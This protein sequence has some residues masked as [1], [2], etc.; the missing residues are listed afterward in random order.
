M[1]EFDSTQNDTFESTDFVLSKMR[2]QDGDLYHSLC[3]DEDVMRYVTGK[4]L[5]RQESEAMF[6]SFMEENAM[7]PPFGRY[8]VMLKETGE[9]IGSAKLE[10][11]D[12]AT[13]IG[14]RLQQQF[15]GRGLATKLAHTLLEYARKKT[16]GRPVIAF[17]NS[18][19]LASIR[20]LQKV[21][22]QQIEAYEYPDELRLKYMY[23]PKSIWTMKTFLFIIFGLIGAVVIAAIIMPKDYSVERSVIV[24]R[25]KSQVFDYLRTLENQEQWSVWSKM[26]PKMEKGYVGMPGTVGSTYHWDS[27]EKEVGAGEQEIKKVQEGERIDF[28]LRF[29]R[30]FESTSQAYLLT[31]GIDS[32]HTKVVW[33]F[34]GSMPIPMNVIMPFMDI[35]NA[36]GKDFDQGL[37]NLKDIL[38]Q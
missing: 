27:K 4:A 13:E 24:N 34:N 35:Q 21:G 12:G 6:Q 17:V 14:Y 9:L 38:E 29:H 26:D 20:V 36:I 37:N 23:Q 25:P 19:N 33:G 22:M 3:T 16:K 28:E 18:E 1:I 31:E 11:F 8:F 15:W 30:P 2:P 32:T 5:N 10:E 7:P